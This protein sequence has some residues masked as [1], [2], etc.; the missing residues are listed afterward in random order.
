MKEDVLL[1]LLPHAFPKQSC[2][3][4]WI[5]PKAGLLVLDT[6]SANRGDTAV[7]ALVR[8]FDGI[9]VAPIQT[10]LAPAGAMAEWLTSQE[11][12]Q[13]FTVDREC[14]LRSSD[15]S[16]AVVRYG[17]HA[18]DIEEVRQHIAS[19]KIPTHL[20]L[21]WNGRV[22][23]QLTDNTSLRGIKFLDG[24]FEGGSKDTSADQFDADVA[25]FTGEVSGLIAD[26][27]DAL[28]GEIAAAEA[29]IEVEAAA[30]TSTTTRH[31]ADQDPLY[32]QALTIVRKK[33]RPSIS[34]V[35]QHLQI[36]YSRAARLLESL[37]HAGVVSHMGPDGAR[38][39]LAVA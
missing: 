35:Q 24:V 6:S 39:L 9:V 18:L 14:E 3:N 5:D 11:P 1:A 2:V 30:P 4:V 19:G 15:E 10:Q 26:L 32:E 7:T 16:K 36:G 31:D 37:E 33:G 25:I 27:L 23:F 20:A 13:G 34:L 8:T 29:V 21:T 17:N 22:S 12:P 38:K 28:G